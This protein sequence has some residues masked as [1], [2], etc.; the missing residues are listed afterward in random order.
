MKVRT[1]KISV[2]IPVY[3]VEQYLEK[4]L[5]TILS[6]T[7][8]DFEIVVV[9]DCSP[10]NSQEIIDLYV[11]KDDRV[12]SVINPVNKGLGGARNVGIMHCTGDYVLFIDS[13]DYLCNNNALK[14]LY[15][16]ASKYDLDVLDT[17][18]NVLENQQIVAVLPKKFN[19][20]NNQVLSGIEYMEQVGI[21]PIVAWNKLYKLSFITTNKILFEERKYEDV[22]FTLETL[23]RSKRVQNTPFPFYNYIVREGSIMTSKPNKTSID[24]ALRLCKDLE[25]QYHKFNKNSQI[26]KSFFYSFV[27][28]KRLLNNYDNKEHKIKTSKEL[29]K[30]HRKYRPSILK[31]KKLGIF[32]KTLLFLSPGVMNYV[33]SKL[34]KR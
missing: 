6:Q 15:N 24:D 31:A 22:C 5:N 30:F 23:Y 10:D 18:Y 17:P 20:F 13:D 27:G 28:L 29:K 25:I 19:V 8:S 21:L 11:L 33:L 2:V 4:C 1:P 9:N 32:Q 34:K 16:Q 14:L 12:K 26:E 3:N 7:F